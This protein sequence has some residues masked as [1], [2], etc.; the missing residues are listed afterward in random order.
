LIIGNA[1]KYK[2]KFSKCT[3]ILIHTLIFRTAYPK[4]QHT[5]PVMLAKC[6]QAEFQV[7]EHL[8]RALVRGHAKTPLEFLYLEAGAIP[9]RFILS[10]RRLI[11]HQTILKR[12]ENE[13]V[14]RIYNEQRKNP[15]VGDFVELV[16]EDFKMMNEVQDDAKIQN[17]NTGGYKKNVKASIRN[18]AFKY[19]TDA[20]AKHSKVS[21]IKYQKLEIQKY[22]VSPIFSN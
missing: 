5:R 14:K 18:A 9:I 21:H 10:S 22:M 3:F 13:L 11:Y 20:L 15:T 6:S 12:E 1:K 17:T 7:D 4:D 19:L 2:T 8:L 16:H